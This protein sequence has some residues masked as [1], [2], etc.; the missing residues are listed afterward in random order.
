MVTVFSTI[1]KAPVL[2]EEH[3]LHPFHLSK[4]KQLCNLTEVSH[5]IPKVLRKIGKATELVQRLGGQWSYQNDPVWQ[6]L[7]VEC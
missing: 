3:I 4:A 1:I 6:E 5:S 2:L 7:V